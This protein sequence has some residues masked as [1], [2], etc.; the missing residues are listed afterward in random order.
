MASDLRISTTPITRRDDLI[1]FAARL[2]GV[3][4]VGFDTEFHSEQ[5]YWPKVMLLQFAS[6]T[7]V[8]LV[9]P[10]A[11]EVKSTLGGF[12]EIMRMREQTLVG[13][14]LERDLEILMRLNGGL[15]TRI[16]DTQVAAAMVGQHGPN[17]YDGGPLGLGGLLEA[18]LGLEIGKLYGRA[19]WGKRPLPEAQARYAAEDVIHLLELETSLSAKLDA[20]GRRPW[21]DAEMKA[22]LDPKR[23]LPTEPDAAWQR[24]SRRPRSGTREHERLAALAAERERIAQE[25]DRPPR[26]VLVDEQLVDLARRG[27]TEKAKLDEDTSRRPSANIERY[28]NRWLD[29]VKTG[30]EAAIR[31]TEPSLD[32]M[33][34]DQRAL[35]DFARSMAHWAS[36]RE[37]VAPWLLPAFEVALRPIVE[38]TELPERSAFLET[39]GLV[40]WRAELIGDSL[41]D[42]VRGEG[43]LAV[44]A[45]P[46]GSRALRRL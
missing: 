25:E 36:R 15:P 29:A 18:E 7:E 5:T 17:G 8:A 11:P 9:D 16:F 43:R 13:H 38:G 19:D 24:V 28:A 30:N 34:P 35:V 45:N 26:R 27:P 42:F 31:G 44:G 23:Y 41:Y 21:F 1:A 10:L 37:G 2:D 22:A 6:P 33:H 12:F 32:G 40:G 39:L 3:S 46:D 14:A 4:M 20:R